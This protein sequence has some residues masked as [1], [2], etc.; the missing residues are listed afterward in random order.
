MAWREGSGQRKK[1]GGVAPVMLSSFTLIKHRHTL[2]WPMVSLR[3]SLA[4]ALV[5][6]AVEDGG[7]QHV[8]H[9]P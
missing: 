6:E 4:V 2:A 3:D 8:H 9:L 5:D 1:Q 7:A